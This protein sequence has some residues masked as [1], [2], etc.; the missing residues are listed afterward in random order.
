MPIR[1]VWDWATGVPELLSDGDH[2]YLVGHDTLGWTADGSWTFILPDALGSVRQTTD[3]TG[4][5]TGS[6]EWSPFGVEIGGTETGLGYTGEWYDVYLQQLYLRA[7]WYAA[8]VG[9]FMQVDP[10]DGYTHIPQSLHV[11]IYAWNDPVNYFDPAGLQTIPGD[12]PLGD[13]CYGGTTGPYN[14]QYPPF[15]PIRSAPRQDSPPVL[16]APDYVAPHRGVLIEYDLEGYVHPQVEVVLDLKL[17]ETHFNRINAGRITGESVIHRDIGVPWFDMVEIGIETPLVEGQN[18][19]GATI[20]LE[21]VYP[22]MTLAFDLIPEGHI[23]VGVTLGLK[24]I[25]FCAGFEEP[26]TGLLAL[27]IEGGVEVQFPGEF[28]IAT[29]QKYINEHGGMEGIDQVIQ[30]A[31]ISGRRVTWSYWPNLPQLEYRLWLK[32]Q[33]S[34]YGN[35]TRIFRYRVLK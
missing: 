1:S 19:L 34:R 33:Q 9:R 26:Y 22:D 10:I 15:I 30:K 28:Y 20:P 3:A 13:V 5:V 12:C 25:M 29:S 2:V 24:D 17:L 4:A 21:K 23:D 14:H 6:R 35:A 11:Y 31:G 7:R 8:Q 18:T 32:N 16:K 27:G